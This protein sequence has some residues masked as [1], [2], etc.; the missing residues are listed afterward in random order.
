MPD[1]E[2][3]ARRVLGA[4]AERR[5]TAATAE[6]LTGG[7]LCARLVDVPGASAVVLGGIVA[8]A[9]PLKHVLLDVPE[10]L[11]AERGPVDPDVALAMAHGARGRLGAD[12]GIATTGVA[13]P[14]PQDGHPPGTVHVA[15]VTPMGGRV[16]SVHLAG[17]RVRVRAGA[18]DAALALVLAALRG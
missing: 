4:L 11:L 17:D 1:D 6:S 9:T 7:L 12:V 16:L 8:Y 2:P 10:S 14:D 5:W 3:A 13:G 15:V 18:V